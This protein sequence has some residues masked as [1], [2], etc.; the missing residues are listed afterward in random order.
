METQTAGLHRPVRLVA[1]SQPRFLLWEQGAMEPDRFVTEPGTP[2][3]LAA[4][5]L[6][7]LLAQ[8]ERCRHAV[9]DPAPLERDI[10]ALLRALDGLHDGRRC[11]AT[12]SQAL[13]Q[14]WDA[15][16]DLARALGVTPQEG[17]APERDRLDQAYG[18]LFATDTAL[19]DR[20]AR[21][22]FDPLERRLMR[23]YLRGLWRNLV[24]RAGA[25][26]TPLVSG[27]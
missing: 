25:V 15:L 27:D 12:T 21:P 5:T 24:A 10:D 11:S 1:R 3:L 13:L 7:E 6:A 9:A 17:S 22:P 8:A 16:E 14:G 18:K 23:R 2:R 4:D 26:G 19:D 20:P